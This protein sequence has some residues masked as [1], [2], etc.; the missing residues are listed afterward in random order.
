MVIFQIESDVYQ[1]VYVGA[2]AD[3]LDSKGKGKLGNTENSNQIGCSRTQTGRW[4]VA[5]SWQ[6]KF[7]SEKCEVMQFSRKNE[8]EQD[9]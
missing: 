6:I 1:G 5:E 3:E 8:E 7:T 4:D 2:I 9:R